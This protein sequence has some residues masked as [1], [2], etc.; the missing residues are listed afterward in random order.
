MAEQSRNIGIFGGTFDPVHNG[1]ISIANSFLNSGEID[2][3]W[4]F[5]NP[6]PPHKNRAPNESYSAR[7]KLL[8]AA[9]ESFNNVRISDLETTLP[10]P[11]YTINTVKKLRNL[12]PQHA[13]FLCMGKDSYVSFKNWYKW[14]NILEYCHLLVADRPGVDH[15]AESGDLLQHTTFVDHEPVK[16]SSTQI[17]KNIATGRSIDDLVPKQVASMIERKHFYSD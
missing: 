10:K 16:V 1:H 15:S 13:L 3:L 17:R 12:Y 14:S 4:V 8:Q 2:E 7:F 5:L 11:C 9:F 6:D